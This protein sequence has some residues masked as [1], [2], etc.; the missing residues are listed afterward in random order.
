MEVR[1]RV[2]CGVGEPAIVVEGCVFRRRAAH[3]LADHGITRIEEVITDNALA[4][5]RAPA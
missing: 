3:Y 4:F 2:I 1:G 5:R